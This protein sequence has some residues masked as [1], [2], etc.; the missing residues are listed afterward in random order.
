[1]KRSL[2]SNILQRLLFQTAKSL[3]RPFPQQERSLP[4]EDFDLSTREG[5]LND[6]D[7]LEKTVLE[8]SRKLNGELSREYLDASSKKTGN[9]SDINFIG[10]R[11]RADS[12]SCIWRTCRFPSAKE[13]VLPRSFLEAASCVCTKT[14]YRDATD[15]LNQFL[16]RTDIN[17][18]K[19]RTLSD[20]ICRIG[21]EISEELSRIA[22]HILTM[23]GF[24]EELSMTLALSTKRI[25]AKKGP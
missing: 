21:A 11:I 15:I 14:S 24:D 23:Y 4:P 16:G 10:I 6:F 25:P 8:T 9:K 18:I 2:L 13:R 1:M 20:S 17:T 5:L 12:H 7:L 19:L 3:K 22:A